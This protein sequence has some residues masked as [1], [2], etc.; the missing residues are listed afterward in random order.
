MHA[1]DLGDE[2]Y[3]IEHW[4]VQ[5]IPTLAMIKSPRAASAT[6]RVLLMGC[7]ATPQNPGELPGVPGEIDK[8]HSLWEAKRPGSVDNCI[9]SFEGSPAQAGYPVSAWHKYQMLH[10]SCHGSFPPQQPFD[11]ALFLGKDA[12]RATELFAVRLQTSLITLSACYLGKQADV[13]GPSGDE[14]IG[15]YIP[16]LYAGARRLLVRRPLDCFW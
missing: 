6:D 5:Y 3:L 10:F 15:I 1:I 8:L 7:P 2:D 9:I 11:A 4:P 14:W 13:V 16:M 12:V